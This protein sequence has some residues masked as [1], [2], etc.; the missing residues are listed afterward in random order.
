M[1]NPTAKDLRDARKVLNR[2]PQK[3]AA[4]KKENLLKVYKEQQKNKKSK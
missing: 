3:I 2:S 4:L 1:K